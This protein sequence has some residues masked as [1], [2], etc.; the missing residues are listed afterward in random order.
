MN[1]TRYNRWTK[2]SGGSSGNR[3]NIIVSI[4]TR[5][6]TKTTV[7]C[8]ISVTTQ[9]SFKVRVEGVYRNGWAEQTLRETP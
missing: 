7:K 3:K 2:H 6:N 1:K 5:H 4:R 9:V 8:F